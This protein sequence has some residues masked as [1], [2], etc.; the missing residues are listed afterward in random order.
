MMLNFA[1]KPNACFKNVLNNSFLTLID[2]ITRDQDPEIL[3]SLLPNAAAIYSIET[4]L[5]TLEKLKDL[6]YRKDYWELNDFHL[7]LIYDS[8][9]F[10]CYLINEDENE[11]EKLFIK[12]SRILYVNF[13]DL[14]DKYF[15]DSDFEYLKETFNQRN[16]N[17][18]EEITPVV[19]KTINRL[20]PSQEELE[21]KLV[22][23][24]SNTNKG[25]L[26]RYASKSRA[27]PA[28]I[29]A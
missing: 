27:Y 8:L 23:R 24:T 17:Y 16:I 25:R 14:V 18:R 21:L 10:Y 22:C 6:N 7:V 13:N 1:L 11:R 3:E 15:P 4:A 5:H 19:W 29:Y 20:K 28:S 9:D 12:N 26:K 2:V